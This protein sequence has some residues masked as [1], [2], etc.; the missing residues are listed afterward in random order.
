MVAASKN[1]TVVRSQRTVRLVRATVQA[2]FVVSDELGSSL[3]ERLFTTPRRH[4]RPERE[5]AVIARGR[6]FEVDVELRSP[7]W[8]NRR[9]RLAAWRGGVGPA[10]PLVP[11]WGGGGPR[12]RAV[13]PP[14]PPPRPSGRG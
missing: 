3:A 5:Q 8:D 7:R 9:I 12:P 4:A 14:P 6:P 2:A 13:L 10:P 1:S 11:G